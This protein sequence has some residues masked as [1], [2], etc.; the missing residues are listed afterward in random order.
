MAE[1]SRS[2]SG[3]GGAG[4]G[5]PW[6]GRFDAGLPP[7]GAGGGGVG[8]GPSVGG[9]FGASAA[10]SSVGG[11]FEA[12]AVGS[13]AEVQLCPGPSI[14]SPPCQCTTTSP[15]RTATVLRVESPIGFTLTR[16][17]VPCTTAVA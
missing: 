17:E 9:G 5:R 3:S 8:A 4:G 15:S 7:G 14:T 2:L 16:N 10:G 13:S 11:G 1:A 6:G 12:G